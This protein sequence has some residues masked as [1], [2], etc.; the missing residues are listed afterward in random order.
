M[1]RPQARPDAVAR[2]RGDRGHRGHDRHGRRV[3]VR[4]GARGVRRR[5]RRGR[6]ERRRRPESGVASVRVQEALDRDDARGRVR[7][8]DGGR[9]RD[10]QLRGVMRTR[11]DRV[12][13]RE[14]CFFFYHHGYRYQCYPGGCSSDTPLTVEGRRQ[15]QPPRATSFLCFF[16]VLPRGGASKNAGTPAH[17][18]NRTSLIYT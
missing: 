4:H 1:E 5:R 18:N 12:R 9:Q 13:R 3:P 7:S 17:R 6:R 14:C 15:N 10:Q 16:N 11:C 2:R 8:G